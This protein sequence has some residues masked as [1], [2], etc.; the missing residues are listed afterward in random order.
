MPPKLTPPVGMIKAKA[1]PFCRCDNCFAWRRKAKTGY[2]FHAFVRC[3]NCH[4]EGPRSMLGE[5]D[6]V[7][8]WDKAIK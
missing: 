3:P 4:A 5:L 7:Y 8:K 1:C 6:A 2:G